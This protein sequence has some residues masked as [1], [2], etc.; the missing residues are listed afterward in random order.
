MRGWGD[1]GMGGLVSSTNFG[2][3]NWRDDFLLGVIPITE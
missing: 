1:E 2:V 3:G